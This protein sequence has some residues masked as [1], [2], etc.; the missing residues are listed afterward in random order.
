[1]RSEGLEDR[2]EGE[3]CHALYAPFPDS[4]APGDRGHFCHLQDT[5]SPLKY[6]A[7]C[8]RELDG[9]GQDREHFLGKDR[10]LLME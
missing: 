9:V 8:L 1:M 2:T 5:A 4:A 3:R 10:F 7:D 6:S